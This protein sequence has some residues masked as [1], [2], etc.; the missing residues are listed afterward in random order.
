MAKNPE[1][2]LDVLRTAV[3]TTESSSWYKPGRGRANRVTQ[4]EEGGL[5]PVGKWHEN[6]R[7]TTH[8]TSKCW[9]PCFNCSA[10][11]HKA[12]HCK[13]PKPNKTVGGA[14]KKAG[15]GDAIKLTK[16]ANKKMKLKKK[17]EEELK[18]KEE[19]VKRAF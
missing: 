14:V 4:E 11:G 17:A 10:Y 6:C 9:G 1:G 7:T 5:A 19:A 8:E 3:K 13:N 12:V 2:N 18:K 16:A 15:D